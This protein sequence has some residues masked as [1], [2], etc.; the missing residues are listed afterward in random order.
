MTHQNPFELRIKY[1]ALAEEARIIKREEAKALRFARR[2]ERGQ[3]VAK[4]GNG[5]DH[6]VSH[7][8]QWQ[9]L[10]SHRLGYPGQSWGWGSLRSEA[11]ATH[12]ARAFLRGTSYGDV[13]PI[14]YTKPAWSATY[15]MV[16]R[17]GSEKDER[18]LSQAFKAWHECDEAPHERRLA[19]HKRLK[20]ARASTNKVERSGQPA[21]AI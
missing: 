16:K 10:R 17:Y 8:T 6:A 1:K 13:E 3:R 7:R 21:Q 11:R 5:T 14:R 18:I 15:A 19:E 20:A 2:L 4:D 9:D 12:L